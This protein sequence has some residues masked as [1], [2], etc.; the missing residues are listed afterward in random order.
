MIEVLK[1]KIS[2]GI[3]LKETRTICRNTLASLPFRVK[4]KDLTN[5]TTLCYTYG[6]LTPDPMKKIFRRL[7]KFYQMND[8][9][10]ERKGA[11]IYMKEME[12]LTGLTDATINQYYFWLKWLGAPLR[13]WQN[14]HRKGRYYDLK[15]GHRF[16]FTIDRGTIMSAMA[17]RKISQEQAAIMTA[18]KKN[19]SL[20]QCIKPITF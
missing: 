5:P 2:I 20:N 19:K 4:K 11:P 1:F 9:L 15:E 8:L 13:K 3:F 17:R 10:N 18:R 14:G 6:W 12:E 7:E 16:D